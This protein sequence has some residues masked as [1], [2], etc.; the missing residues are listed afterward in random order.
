MEL[1][2]FADWTSKT[3][4]LDSFLKKV[5]NSYEFIATFD[6]D[7]FLFTDKISLPG[8]LQMIFLIHVGHKI[9][10]L[11]WGMSWHAINASVETT[12]SVFKSFLGNGCGSF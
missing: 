8:T 7:C 1:K 12:L 5:F 9:V 2:P 4:S 3:V 11:P 6:P 10:F